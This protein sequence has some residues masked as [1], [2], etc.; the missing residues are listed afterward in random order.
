MAMV[1]EGKK[2]KSF[3][4]FGAVCFVVAI[5]DILT[6]SIELSPNIKFNLFYLPVILSGILLIMLFFEWLFDLIKK[7]MKQG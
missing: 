4:V 1:S 2:V 5:F 6:L 3:L 7:R